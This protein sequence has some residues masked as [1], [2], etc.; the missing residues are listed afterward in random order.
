MLLNKKVKGKKI[1]KALTHL[2]SL[3]KCLEFS[4]RYWVLTII[5][6]A[7]WVIYAL[8][9]PVMSVMKQPVLE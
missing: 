2:K 1:L 9:I 5:S 4:N 3:V 6:L 8:L 7:T